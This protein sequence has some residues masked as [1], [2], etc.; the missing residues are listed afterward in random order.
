[1]YREF[2]VTEQSK[3]KLSY[4]SELHPELDKIDIKKRKFNSEEAK[5]SVAKKSSKK[6][7]NN[8]A[9]G[10]SKE[11]LCENSA[12]TFEHAQNVIALFK[13]K[14]AELEE[15]ISGLKIGLSRKIQELVYL[16]KILHDILGTT[17]M[18]YEIPL[19]TLSQISNNLKS[20]DEKN[21]DI[22]NSNGVFKFIPEIEKIS[23]TPSILH[24]KA[25][26]DSNEKLELVL[27]T[28]RVIHTNFTAQNNMYKENGVIFSLVLISKLKNTGRS[29][30]YFHFNRN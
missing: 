5:S 16:S 13:N 23:S 27:M 10:K 30:I 24:D 29:V 3:S 15:S 12:Q 11:N 1:L 17:S 20:V 19:D 6:K 22:L 2:Q 21:I 26:N 9:S 14:S 8:P 28:S 25:S 4:Q 7:K 18:K